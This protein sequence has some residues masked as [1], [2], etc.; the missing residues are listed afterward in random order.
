MQQ[1]ADGVETTAAFVFVADHR[2]GRFGRVGHLE[3]AANGLRIVVPA[4]HGRDVDGRELPALQ[5]VLAAFAEAAALFVLA[6]GEPEL[7]DVRAA[8]DE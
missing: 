2:P 3:H 6:H 5:R 7:D 4:V 8:P 1:H